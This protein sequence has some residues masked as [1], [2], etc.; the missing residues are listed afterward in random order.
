MDITP[1]GDV[2]PA[3]K[4]DIDVIQKTIDRQFGEGC[5]ESVIPDN[6]VVLLN[7]APALD[8][9]DEVIMDGEV[10]GTM[11]YDI[12]KGWTFLS[13]MPAARCIVNKATK[14]IVTTDDGAIKPILSGSNLLAPGVVSTSDDLESGDEVIAVSYTHLRAHET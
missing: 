1:P 4:H 7:K 13:R 9:M 3:F 10:I 8:R 6:H 2:R 11:R 12:G 5:G 14:G